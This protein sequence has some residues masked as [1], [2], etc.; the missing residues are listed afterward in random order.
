MQSRDTLSELVAKDQATTG[1]SGELSTILNRFSLAGRMVQ[2]EI[3]RAGF[4]GKLGYTGSTNVQGEEVRALDE[5]AN[6]IFISVFEPIDTVSCLASEENEDIYYYPGDRTGKYLLLFDPLDGSSNVDVD[7]PMG[8]IFSVHRRRGDGAPNIDDFLQK[9]TEQVAA[10][11]VL[12]GPSTMFVYTTGGPVRGFTLD[13]TIGTFFLTHPDMQIPNGR[14]TYSVNESNEDKWD[15]NTK[16]MV[17]RFRAGE[18][19]CGKRT[20]RYIGALVADFHRTLIKGGLF[21]YPGLTNKPEGKLRL[22][23]ECS[24]LAMVIKQA[25]G[26][27]STGTED[28]LEFQPTELHQRVPF[29][30]GSQADVEEAIRLLHGEG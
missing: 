27:A 19:K 9:G 16:E 23:Y 13:R 28:V 4:V 18:T 5:I 10:G 12:Y 7:G 8:S 22:L 25:G 26:Y 15:D 29:Y 3:M 14:G 6:D 2:A 20:A 21:L 17:R 30:C 24:P 1:G 11:Y